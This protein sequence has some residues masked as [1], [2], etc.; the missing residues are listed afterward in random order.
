MCKSITKAYVPHNVGKEQGSLTMKV[1][2]RDLWGGG[3]AK[4]HVVPPPA[5]NPLD[6]SLVVYHQ[7]SVAWN[8]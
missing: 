1:E 7:V 6:P 8:M 5:G 4:K 2:E 3:R